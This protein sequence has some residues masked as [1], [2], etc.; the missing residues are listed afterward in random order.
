MQH[1]AVADETI[2]EAIR[3]ILFLGGPYNLNKLDKRYSTG[4][5]SAPVVEQPI[6]ARISSTRVR[7]TN[8]RG[9]VLWPS[10]WLGFDLLKFCNSTLLMKGTS[11]ER[12]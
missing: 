6:L 5:Y 9:V 3:Q 10:W 7:Q 2:V 4:L 1:E 11:N 12:T 8:R